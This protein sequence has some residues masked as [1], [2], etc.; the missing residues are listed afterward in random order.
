VTV[1]DNQVFVR[2]GS[3]FRTAGIRIEG[4]ATNVT[5]HDNIIRGCSAGITTETATAA[6]QKID[7]ARCVSR[8]FEDRQGPTIEPPLSQME[9]ALAQRSQRGQA[10]TFRQF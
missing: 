9:C 1:S 3:N 8:R 7:R 10:I 5:I 6:V 4:D 2:N